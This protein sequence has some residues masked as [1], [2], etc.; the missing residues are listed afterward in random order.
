[1]ERDTAPTA[2]FQ[3]GLAWLDETVKVFRADHPTWTEVECRHW[4]AVDILDEIRHRQY[5]ADLSTDH[6]PLYYQPGARPL[7]LTPEERAELDAA[8]V[9][10]QAYTLDL[11]SIIQANRGIYDEQ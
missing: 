8:L 7:R 10:W 2:L 6:K 1:M 11:A 4:L 5:R 3:R 9:E